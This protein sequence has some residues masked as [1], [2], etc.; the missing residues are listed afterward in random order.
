MDFTPFINLGANAILAWLV[1]HLVT[2][3]LPRIMD[4]AAV[5]L[6]DARQSYLAALQKTREEHT[7]AL[8]SLASRIDTHTE[9][10]KNLCVE[11]ANVKGAVLTYT[12][13]RGGHA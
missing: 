2:N 3:S 8:S 1:W 5:E 12:G 4:R 7:E 6:S 13:K 11:L 10:L 9:E